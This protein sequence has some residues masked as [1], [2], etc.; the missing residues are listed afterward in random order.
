MTKQ[1]Q[2]RRHNT[3]KAI[4]KLKWW[5]SWNICFFFQLAME[6]KLAEYKIR[7]IF[8]FSKLFHFPSRFDFKLESLQLKTVSKRCAY[9][10]TC[11]NEQKFMLHPN[12]WWFMCSSL[13]VKNVQEFIEEFLWLIN[14][15]RWFKILFSN[16]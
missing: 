7:Q 1:A 4:L 2:R 3:F 10:P 6:Y 12:I 8:E 5:M 13:K 15:F 11:C 14:K 16:F 9:I